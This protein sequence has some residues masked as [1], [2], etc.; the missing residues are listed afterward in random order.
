M[1]SRV[2]TMDLIAGRVRQI[3]AG[4]VTYLCVLLVVTAI[5]SPPL[6]N[7]VRDVMMASVSPFTHPQPNV[8]VVAI[9]EQG[10]A[11]FPYRS[12]VDRGLVADLVAKI[13][14]AG[15]R[16]IGIDLLLDQA[17]EPAKDARLQAAI[18][19]ASS[20]IVIAS[21]WRS[22]GLTQDQFNYL[23]RF[24]PSARRGLALLLHDNLDGVVRGAFHGRQDRA[25]W[26]PSFAAAMASPS[27][28]DRREPDDMV[29]YREANGSPFKFPVYPAQAIKL[30]PPAWF[31][32]KYVLIGVDLP[33]VD[34]HSTPF[35]LLSGPQNGVLP[36][37]V[38]HAHSLASLLS[39]DRIV[40]LSPVVGFSPMVAAGILCLWIAWRPMK[41]ALKPPIIMSVLLFVWLSEA[42]A[43][44]HSAILI[45]MVAPA[46]L[47]L[48]GSALVA[49]LAW[50]RDAQE[51]QFIQQAFS[52]YVS[53]AVVAAI[54]RKPALLSLGGERRM[55]TSVFT[56]IEGF[57]S[58][59][60][61]LAP[62]VLA[63]M[64]NE[65][66]SGMCELF[67][68][69]GATIDKVVGDA[70]VGFFGAPAGQADQANR[71][72]ALTLAIH[73]FVRR[74]RERSAGRNYSLGATRIGVHC[75]PAIVGNFGGDRFFNYTAIGDTVNTAARLESA[76][77]YIR[78]ENCISS[79]VVNETS[80]FVVR[81]SGI[82]FLK[83][84]EDGIEA[85]EVLG[86][87]QDN[88]VR[89]GEYVKAYALMAD[90]SAGA[91][92]VF[93]R[94]SARYPGDGL[95]SFHRDRLAAGEIG[96]EIRLGGK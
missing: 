51:R 55:I 4:S 16:A 76:N 10:L 47:L 13:D 61:K 30:A 79:H 17:T 73:D 20:P 60:E 27:P 59:S 93:E 45:P 72:V 94:L 62:E 21:A 96:P 7:V 26:T 80:G 85:F 44:V 58:L 87:T 75:G 74:V 78:T 14:V 83:G 70:V 29:F 40:T 49:F 9:T 82:L 86:D 77:K 91:A 25:G 64:L 71:A 57:T 42:F 54:A 8:V 24:A 90:R 11:T 35:A 81:P 68:E 1:R 48:G 50:R 52:K 5:V 46:L 33:N 28:S 88:R 39:G 43:F 32:D 53:P 15:P 38:I 19:A 6:E 95:I 89:Q 67:V 18:G 34:R 12:P 92:Q 23:N 22:D 65:H 36:G 2:R 69:H 66:L 56:D 3:V 63:D 41:V 84:K 37:V 31:K